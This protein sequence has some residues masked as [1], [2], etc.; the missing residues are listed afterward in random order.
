ML[1]KQNWKHSIKYINF[2]YAP[3]K[4]T[5]V[6]SQ[7]PQIWCSFYERYDPAD[8]WLSCGYLKLDQDRLPNVSTIQISPSSL[9]IVFPGMR[10]NGP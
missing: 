4:Y 10:Q 3:R 5:N 8:E 1:S 6:H 7:S 9:S 2:L